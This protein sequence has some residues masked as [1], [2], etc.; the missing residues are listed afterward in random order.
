MWIFSIQ[1][2]LE[3][4]SIFL[5]EPC[6]SWLNFAFSLDPVHCSTKLSVWAGAADYGRKQIDYRYV[7]YMTP[8]Q[9]TWT[10]PLN[11]QVG[12]ISWKQVRSNRGGKTDK[13]RKWKAKP[14]A[15]PT[16]TSLQL[17]NKT[18]NAKTENSNHNMS[19]KKVFIVGPS[20]LFLLL[21]LGSGYVLE[22][23]F[24]YNPYA[25]NLYLYQHDG[26]Q[27]SDC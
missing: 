22:T 3:L 23:V 12:W 14:K 4:L 24:N 20:S 7:L 19:G 21:D 2:T 10:I 1:C 15:W 25:F 18:G 8:L 17:Q 9:K 26:L 6:F 13:G 11:T 16:R 5:R 27:F